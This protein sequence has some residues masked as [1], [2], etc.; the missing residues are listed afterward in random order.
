MTQ[1]IAPSQQSTTAGVIIVVPG[2]TAGIG[3]LT[4]STIQ[5]IKGRK[6]SEGLTAPSRNK[7]NVEV[8][9]SIVGQSKRILRTLGRSVA[10][11]RLS[12]ATT[13][14]KFESQNDGSNPLLKQHGDLFF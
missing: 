4:D 6:C 1:R 5:F 9:F 14:V 3:T 2:F 8:Y 7:R 12:I 11:P 10:C 13:R